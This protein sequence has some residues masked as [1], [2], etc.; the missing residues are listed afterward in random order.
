VITVA[1]V[2][3][4]FMGSAH[5]ANY[6]ALDGRVRVKTVASR[7]LDRA[8]RLAESVGAEATTDLD[9]VLRDP[10]VDAVDLCV[11]TALHRETAE[12]AL[13]A[14]KHVFL[15]KPIALTLHD[16]DA[17]VRA[18]GASGK[19]FMVGLVLRF[20]PEYVELQRRLASGELGPIRAVSTHRLSPPADWNE[21]MADSAQ[22]GGVPVDLLIHDFDQ[23]N[24][25]LGT[26]LSVFAREPEPGHVLALVEYDGAS[27]L[28]EGSMRMPRC[29]PFSSNIRALCEGGAAEYSFSAAPA[30]D[31]GNIGAVTVPRGLS[32]YP[33]DGDPVA[34]PVESVDPWG[35]EIAYFVECV[36]QGRDPE[37]GTGDQAR[38][39]LRLSLAT[40]R[41]LE[42]G[43]PE[44]V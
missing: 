2:G 44:P 24:W 28:A 18:A 9:A 25:L 36:E 22:S 15:E 6:K 4:G 7:S 17:I 40:N 30:E 42:S 29:Y 23:M 43:R 37:H 20:W 11:P 16:A 12:R 38:E 21:W 31:G 8:V 13:G 41:S 10:D 1:V 19:V 14:G 39:A 34:V 26:P 3:A 32:L 5:T 27:G 33:A 35:P